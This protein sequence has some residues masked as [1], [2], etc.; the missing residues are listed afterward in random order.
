MS[1]ETELPFDYYSMPFCAPPEGIRSS[2]GSINPGTILMGSR[3]ENS[4]YNFSVKV[5]LGRISAVPGCARPDWALRNN[6]KS[7]WC[8]DWHVAELRQEGLRSSSHT[9]PGGDGAG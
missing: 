5:L 4:P 6:L 8:R 3:I 2:V 1:P 7:A 9:P